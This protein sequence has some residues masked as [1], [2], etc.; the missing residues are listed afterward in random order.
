MSHNNLQNITIQQMESLIRLVEERSF[1]RA[2]QKM[3]LT[4]PSLTKHIKNLEKSVDAILVNRKN[5]GI[6]L[7][8]EGEIIHGYARRIF[9]LMDEAKEKIERVRENESGS[10]FISASTIPSTYILPHVLMAFNKDY[11]DIHCYVQMN[12]S[13]ATLNMILDN[14]AEI[15]FV[16]G[17]V[18][19][20]KLNIEPV[21]NDR[22]VLIIPKGHRWSNKEVVTIDE[23]SREPFIVR[24]KGSAT[25]SS[26]EEYLRKNTDKT[27]SLFNVVCEMGS[28]EA[29]KEAV[30]AGLG[31]SILSIHAVKRELEHGL[32]CEKT[33]EDCT[34]ERNFHLIY[35][36][37]LHLM[38]HH[39]LFLAFVKKSKPDFP[40]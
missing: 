5:T 38:K 3:Y 25:R 20:N 31:I 12:D 6:S 39:K 23:V 10:V 13:D 2:A 8:P 15:G 14:Q 36:K 11:A 40:C 28:S 17:H 30:I 29:I 21:W 22:L 18:S 32:V 34:I 35:K 1:G 26:L 37:Q 9:K 33:V 16:G 24:E 4:Q 7:T 19:S 27:L